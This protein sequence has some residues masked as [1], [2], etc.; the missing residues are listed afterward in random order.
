MQVVGYSYHCSHVKI[1]PK[2]TIL[3]AGIVNYNCLNFFLRFI[4]NIG[5]VVAAFLQDCHEATRYA[6]QL[7]G[8]SLDKSGEIKVVMCITSIIF[9]VFL[10]L[11]GQ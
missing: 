11:C 5:L 8:D 1:F 2:R 6:R 4:N 3:T 10:L 9:S 7:V